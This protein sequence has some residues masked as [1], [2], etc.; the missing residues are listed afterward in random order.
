[1][2]YVT[3]GRTGLS[4]S[5]AGLGCGGSSRLGLRHGATV[6]ESV[7]LVH[8]ALDLGVTFFDTAQAYGTEEI[9]GRALSGVR[10]RVVISTKLD[11]RE[12][13]DGPRLEAPAL[14]RCVESSLGALATDAIDVLHFH[15]P[16]E[17]EYGYIVAE[18]IP[19]LLDLRD[20]GLIRFLAMSE[21]FRDDPGHSLLADHAL[22]DACWDVMMLGFNILNPSARAR[23]LPRTRDQKVG[24]QVMYA[25]RRAFS[26]LDT[27]RR[28]IDEAVARGA[29]DREAIDPDD[30]LGFLVH[31]GGASSLIDAAYRFARHEPGCDVILTGTGS[32][33]HL[34]E[35]VRS[36]TAPPLPGDDLVRLEKLFGEVDFLTGN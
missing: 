19:E 20:R 27:L 21:S 1:M 5:V 35:N 25:V 3:F 22:D 7:A 26:H 36:I 17:E 14:R 4:V 23:V 10:D 9:L 34:R 16:D 2:E 32:V 30:P 28:S 33:E 8:E 6:D 24:V 18:L 13:P 12:E 31:D 15:G 11:L 29:V